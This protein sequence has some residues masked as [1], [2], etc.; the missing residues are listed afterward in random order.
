MDPATLKVAFQLAVT[1]GRSRALRRLIIAVTL[2]WTLVMV[3][4][5]LIPLQVGSRLAARAQYMAAAGCAGEPGFAVPIL[6]NQAP[7]AVN[8]ATWNTRRANSTRRI[9]SGLQTIATAGADVIGVQELAPESRR[10]QVRRAMADLGWGMS[11]HDN[12]VPIFYRRAKYTVLAQDSKKVFDVRRIEPGVAG[13]SI[14][15]KSIQWLQLRDR[16]TGAA[17]VAANHHLVPTIDNR[18]RPDRTNPKRVR[19]AT[20]QLDAAGALVDRLA[21]AGPLFLT[22]DWNIDARRDGSIRDNRWPFVALGGHG[23]RSNWRVLGYPHRGT[24]QGGARLIDYVMSTTRAAVPIR[25]R[26][27]GSYGSDHSAV[28]VTESN[29]AGIADTITT[30]P[31]PTTPKQLVVPGSNPGSTMTLTGEQVSNAAI[32]IAEGRAAGIPEYGWVIGLA[33]AL[34]ESGIKMLDYGDRDSVNMF[35]QR[36]SSGWGNHAELSDPHLATRAFYGVADHTHNPGLTDITGWKQMS[37]TAAAQAVQ[38]SGYPGAYAKWEATARSIVQ[39]LADGVAPE[40][41]EPV[42]CGTGADEKLGEC[43][44]SGSAAEHGLTRDALLTLRC[45]HGQFP[46]ITTFGGVH[47]DPLPDHPS[48]RAVDF[49]IDNYQTSSGNAYGWQLAHWL[50]DHRTELGVSY[51]IFDAKIWSVARNGEGWRDYRPGYTSH[52]DDSSMHRNHVHVTVFGDQAT[53]FHD[54][55]AVPA[56]AWTMPLAAGSYRVGCGF[57]C[58]PGHTG[59]DFPAPSGTRVYAATDGVVTRSTALRDQAGNYV[60]YG[61]L[62]VIKVA[63]G[64]ELYHAHLQRRLV[65][66]GDRVRA[67][68][69]IAYSGHT[70]NVRPR[71]EGGAHLH[72]E[73]RVDGRPVDPM[74]ILRQKGLTWDDER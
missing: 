63:G 68:Q 43:G 3:G 38:R 69:L 70:G 31:T 15:P 22:A 48:G 46:A 27:L 51:V 52:L 1:V 19:L 45:V 37:V 58:Y 17:F 47:P 67:G 50:R 29:H 8:M 55:P 9:I 33:A 34:Q 32:I 53:G 41:A 74:P 4:V 5:M 24:H 14:G 42:V 21:K 62:I 59:Q 54:N 16:S 72:F 40:S 6:G 18:G 28:L 25:Q 35:Q 61:N 65:Q 13:T 71:G 20:M 49:M 2:A 56:G 64:M 7:L 57:G 10:R 39:Q 66:V 11:R 30:K 23:L 12:A 36:P 44:P 73:I 60:S 26:I